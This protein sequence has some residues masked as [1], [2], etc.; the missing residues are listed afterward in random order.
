VTTTSAVQAPGGLRKKRSEEEI[1]RSAAVLLSRND[2]WWATTHATLAR[3]AHYPLR[4]TDGRVLTFD[5]QGR[6]EEHHPRRRK[7]AYRS[8]GGTPCKRFD[9]CGRKQREHTR[10]TVCKQCAFQSRDAKY[11]N[12]GVYS[13]GL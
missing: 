4:S 10:R 11:L 6:K 8:A 13:G 1:T 7:P 2:I 9:E 3:P 12:S 5:S